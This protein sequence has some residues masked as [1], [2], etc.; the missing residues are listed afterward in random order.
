MLQ[1]EFEFTLPYGYADEQGN[2][3]RQGLMRRATALD[4]IE[5]MGHPRV[6]ANEAYLAVALLSRVLLR[7]G[8]I[9]PVGPQVV[10]RLFAADFIFLQDLY[11]RLNG[12]E[13]GLIETRCPACGTHFMLD[14]Y[15]IDSAA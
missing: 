6:R 4:E 7:L 1:T 15:G 9:G 14:P 2:L 11:A 13:Q 8:E 12:G 10:E 3:H 5:A